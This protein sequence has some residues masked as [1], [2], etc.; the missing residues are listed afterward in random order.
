MSDS[1]E[2]SIDVAIAEYLQTVEAGSPPDHDA[3]LAKYSDLRGELEQFLADR[4][5][6][7]HA[8][9]PL[10]PDKTMAPLMETD[11]DLKV[12][13]YFG[14]YELIDEIARG[15]MG[16]VWKA[17]QVSLNRLVA[18]KMILAG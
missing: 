7:R 8:A 17:R 10:D 11:G 1:H 6:F 3:W 9:E 12:V 14:D 4:S 13:R 2:Q 15:G 5:A 16:V 18:V